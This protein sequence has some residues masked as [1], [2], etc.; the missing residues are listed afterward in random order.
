MLVSYLAVQ[1]T[2]DITDLT[3]ASIFSNIGKQT[4]VIVRFS[5][6]SASE[7]SPEWTRNPAASP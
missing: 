7:G 1:V 5:I 4:P 2:D 3:Y 6:V